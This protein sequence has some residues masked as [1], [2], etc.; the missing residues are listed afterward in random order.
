MFSEGGCEGVFGCSGSGDGSFSSRTAGRGGDT[1]EA[2]TGAGAFSA[3][4]SAGVG[5]M[6]LGTL[7][8]AAVLTWLSAGDFVEACALDMTSVIGAV[9]AVDLCTGADSILAGRAGVALGEGVALLLGITVDIG[10]DSPELPVIGGCAPGG[11]GNGAI[12]ST[13]LSLAAAAAAADAYLRVSPGGRVGKGAGFILVFVMPF[14]V[15]GKE[16]WRVAKAGSGDLS[17][18]DGLLAIEVCGSDTEA[19]F[20]LPGGGFD[21]RPSAVS[22]RS[23]A[24]D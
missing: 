15:V 5:G 18:F 21:P 8:D 22:G 23:S 19:A 11:G 14:V 6:L 16:V 20:D 2:E 13:F 9:V 10:G 24:T 17:W 3:F 4:S 12:P 1:F 7:A